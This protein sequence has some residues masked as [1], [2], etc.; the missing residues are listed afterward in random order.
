MGKEDYSLLAPSHQSTDQRCAFFF[1][2]MLTWR[3]QIC[4]S[5]AVH[6]LTEVTSLADQTYLNRIQQK[7]AI[8]LMAESLGLQG[9]IIVLNSV[10]GKC[11]YTCMFLVQTYLQKI[12]KMEREQKS[13]NLNIYAWIKFSAA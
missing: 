5:V 11:V 4:D 8:S 6:K 3:Y 12:R 9:N 7:Q 10:D 1:W 2:C 13:I